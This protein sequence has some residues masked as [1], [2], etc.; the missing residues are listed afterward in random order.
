LRGTVPVEL[1]A[2]TA[3][4]GAHFDDGAL[5]FR[6]GSLGTLHNE[7]VS[8]V[9]ISVNT[10]SIGGLYVGLDCGLAT[11]QSQKEPLVDGQKGSP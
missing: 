8:V 10:V 11:E 2:K 3:V 1:R 4:G 7:V 6:Q 5:S 9:P